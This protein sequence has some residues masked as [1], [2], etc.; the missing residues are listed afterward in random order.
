[1]CAD[2]IPSGSNVSIERDVQHL[3]S[4][5]VDLVDIDQSNLSNACKDSFRG[6]RW[7]L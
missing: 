4:A 7:L 1:M 2:S 5:Y 3:H 6:L